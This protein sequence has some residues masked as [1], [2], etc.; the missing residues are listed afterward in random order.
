MARPRSFLIQV[1]GTMNRCKSVCLLAI[2][3]LV[4]TACS[5]GPDLR[6]SERDSGPDEILGSPPEPG[7]EDYEFALPPGHPAQEEQ[8]A[9]PVEWDSQAESFDRFYLERLQQYGPSMILQHVHTEAVVDEGQFVGFELVS[10]SPTAKHYVEPRLQ[11]GD[12]VTHVNLV[13]LEK[14]DDY[15]EAWETLDGA[16][17]VRIDVLRNG[18]PTDVVWSIQ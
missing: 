18:E 14:P 8:A 9:P 4:I 12:V 3:S 16:E 17:E 1:V 11:E 6:E 15:M 2:L 13:R 7:S 10:M 5:T